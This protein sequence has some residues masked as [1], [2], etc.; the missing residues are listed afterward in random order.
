MTSR[1]K[2]ERATVKLTKS[3]AAML[4]SY[5]I[6]P[7][8]IADDPDVRWEAAELATDV[9]NAVNGHRTDGNGWLF[10]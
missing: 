10:A 6:T 4:A 8:V 3:E 1:H 7:A 5:L 9:A 2:R